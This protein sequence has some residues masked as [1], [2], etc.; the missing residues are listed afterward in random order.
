MVDNNL[1]SMGGRFIRDKCMGVNTTISSRN[2]FWIGF[3]TSQWECIGTQRDPKEN[4]PHASWNYLGDTWQGLCVMMVMWQ[5][6]HGKDYVSWWWCGRWQWQ[7]LC[8]MMV[9]WQMTHGKEDVPCWSYGRWHM[10]RTMCHGGDMARDMEKLEFEEWN[11]TVKIMSERWWRS[12][13]NQVT[14]LH[15]IDGV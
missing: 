2:Q 7:G 3:C 15:K 6:T 9:M 8:V 11:Q 1:R 5:V 13:H 10:E 14:G 4:H 12:Y